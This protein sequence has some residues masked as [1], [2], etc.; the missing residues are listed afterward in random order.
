MIDH[1]L[2]RC[3]CS[4]GGSGVLKGLV[5]FICLLQLCCRSLVIDQPCTVHPFNSASQGVTNIYTQ[6]YHHTLLLACQLFSPIATGYVRPIYP[7]Y[8]TRC[9][10]VYGFWNLK[11]QG[12]IFLQN[13]RNQ[14]CFPEDQNP[15]KQVLA[16]Y[17][18]LLCLWCS[19]AVTGAH[20]VGVRTETICISVILLCLW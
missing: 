11:D 10:F 16:V 3:Y 9:G 7:C 8:S 15:R 12:N 18:P 4:L 1:Y 20:F 14:H 2:V 19:V 13:D 5:A 6:A 17:W